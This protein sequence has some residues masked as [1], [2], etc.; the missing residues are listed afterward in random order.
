MSLRRRVALVVSTVVVVLGLRASRRSTCRSTEI[1][2]SGTASASRRERA[3]GTDIGNGERKRRR[4]HSGE[5]EHET[6]GNRR[7]MPGTRHGGSTRRW[8]RAGSLRAFCQTRDGRRETLREQQQHLQE[9]G[10]GRDTRGWTAA[11]G[12]RGGGEGDW[13]ELGGGRREGRQEQGEAARDEREGEGGGRGGAREEGRSAA[14]G[15]GAGPRR[16]LGAGQAGASRRRLD[17]G[18]SR[19]GVG[20]RGHWPEWGKAR[21]RSRGGRGIGRAHV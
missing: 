19:G 16:G 11:E 20:C 10:A 14:S 9:G 3:S 18:R 5:R 13:E 12:R 15:N 21:E 7:E 1:S 4:E 17:T 8:K 6:S 2:A